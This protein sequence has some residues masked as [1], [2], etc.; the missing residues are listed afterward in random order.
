MGNKIAGKESGFTLMELILVVVVMGIVAAIAIPA[1]MGFLPGMRVNGAARQIMS[2]LMDARMEAVK[3]NHEYKVFFLNNHEYKILDDNDSDGVD[4]GGAETSR[5][6]DIQ[7]NY[8]D[9]T[10]SDTGDPVFSPKG[11][12]ITL[13]TITVQNASGSKTVSISIAGRVKVE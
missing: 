8:S 3:Q 13:S 6:V 2:D 1:F 12:A 4:D 5:T 10:L 11:T 7:D 9:V